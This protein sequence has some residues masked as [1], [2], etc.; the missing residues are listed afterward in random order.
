MKENLG[1]FLLFLFLFL[2]F[3]KILLIVFLKKNYYFVLFFSR[4]KKNK[5]HF[6]ILRFNKKLVFS[7]FLFFFSSFKSKKF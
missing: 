2:I 1:V 5:K 4:L 7:I 6:S 3:K